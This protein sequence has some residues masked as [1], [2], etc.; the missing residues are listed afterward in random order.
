M[1]SRM[2]RPRLQARMLRFSSES[3]PVLSGRTRTTVPSLTCRRSGQREP[4]LTTQ[5][6]WMVVSTPSMPSTSAALAG[7]PVLGMPRSV[8]ATSPAVPAATEDQVRKDRR[9]GRGPR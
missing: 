3:S 6:D 1:R 4:Q 5:A 7:V 9:E 8:A 2:L